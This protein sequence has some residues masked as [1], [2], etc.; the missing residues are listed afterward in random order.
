MISVLR[1]N[2]RRN[3]APDASQT[4]NIWTRA[5]NK[6]HG[7][8]VRFFNARLRRSG[9]IL[10]AATRVAPGSKVAPGT[11]FGHHT[12]V[13]GAATIKGSG[14]ATIGPYGAIGDG[15]VIS[16]SNHSTRFANVQ[17]SLHWR[18][19][20]LDLDERGDVTVGPGC[21]I[22]DNVCIMAGVSVGAGAVL[23]AG[24]VVTRDVEPYTIVGGV[25]ARVLRQRC[26]HEV[27]KVLVSSK[28]W[29]WDDDRIAR[30][31]AFF[32]AEIAN[33]TPSELRSLIRP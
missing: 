17:C 24:C 21:W 14:R 28:W 29:D 5:S 11:I 33:V 27:A 12:V 22:G 6:I 16:T 32:E 26:A 1:A 25:P 31:R 9:V 23:A 4:A 30:N 15:L 19:G 3:A 7:G 2:F 18:H 10:G 13:N 20:F 8:L